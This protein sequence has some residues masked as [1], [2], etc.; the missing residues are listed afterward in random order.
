MLKNSSVFGRERKVKSFRSPRSH[1]L[2]PLVGIE[3]MVRECD[4]VAYCERVWRHGRR[5]S[6]IFAHSE[7]RAENNKVKSF[8]LKWIKEFRRAFGSQICP[9]EINFLSTEVKCCHHRES[10]WSES[11]A[12]E[13]EESDDGRWRWDG[14]RKLIKVICL[15]PADTVFFWKR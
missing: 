6:A 15:A 5:I 1:F 10:F 11:T 7:S 13:R 12:A 3:A 8:G 9:L 2:R 4:S 14:G